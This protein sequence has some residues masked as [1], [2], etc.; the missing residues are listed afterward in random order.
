MRHIYVLS[1]YEPI[2]VMRMKSKY[3]LALKN[4]NTAH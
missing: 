1:R 4:S 3:Y 2:Y